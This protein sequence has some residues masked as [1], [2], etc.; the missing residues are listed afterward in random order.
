MKGNS[1]PM[2]SRLQ[3]H[4]VQAQELGRLSQRNL[5]GQIGSKRSGIGIFGSPFALLVLFDCALRE[6]SQEPEIQGV[7]ENDL[8]LTRLLDDRHLSTL[9]AI[10]DL[11]GL[12]GQIG[13]GD[14]GPSHG[15]SLHP[16]A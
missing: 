7:Q 12:L 3:L 1:E 9:N 16:A 14:Q 10:D 11:L 8:L 4:Q 6:S 2:E 5:S 13:L 15:G